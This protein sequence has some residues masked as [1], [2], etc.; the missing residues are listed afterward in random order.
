MPRIEDIVPPEL[1]ARRFA[2]GYYRVDDDG[3]IEKR[4]STCRDYWPADHEFFNFNSKESDG[5]H[6]MCR[7][8]QKQSTA[9]SKAK[10]TAV[11]NHHKETTHV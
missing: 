11:G 8:C 2:S 7:D 1:L 3:G 6:C 10:G 4:C 9:R 5:L